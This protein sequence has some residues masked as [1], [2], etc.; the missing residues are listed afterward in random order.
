MLPLQ[1]EYSAYL[2]YNKK[3]PVSIKSFLNFGLWSC[4]DYSMSIYLIKLL[5]KLKSFCTT[6]GECFFRGLRESIFLTK[7]LFFLY[8]LNESF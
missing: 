5:K 2:K 6:A 8:C 3:K 1:I 4:F 7:K